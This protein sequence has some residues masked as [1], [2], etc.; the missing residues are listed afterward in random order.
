MARHMDETKVLLSGENY[1][2]IQ[3]KKKGELGID[4]ESATEGR[5][6]NL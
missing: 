6:D 2:K 5:E 4:G 1:R 3:F